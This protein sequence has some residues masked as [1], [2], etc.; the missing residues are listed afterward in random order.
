MPSPFPG[1]D[2]YLESP[3]F[4]ADFH[5]SMIV[6]MKAVL[7]RGL[8]QNYFAQ[9]SERLWVETTE[10]YVVPDVSVSRT[11]TRRQR[12]DDGGVASAQ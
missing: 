8:P 9:A 5:D 4:F 10:R 11:A 2:P 12:T 7:Q 3:R 1:M 6:Y